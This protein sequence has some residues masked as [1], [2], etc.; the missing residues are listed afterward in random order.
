MLIVTTM[1]GYVEVE[2]P[3]QDLGGGCRH[4]RLLGVRRR[5]GLD[6]ISPRRN[7]AG[8]VAAL[9]ELQRHRQTI[10]HGLAVA[11]Y[12]D[13]AQHPLGRMRMCHMV[14]DSLD[15]LHAMAASVGCRREW[16]QPR[17]FPHYDLPLFRRARAVALGA[18][19]VDRRELARIMRRVRGSPNAAR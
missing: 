8:P 5:R 16:F 19:E 3:V 9:R 10:R 2:Q 4:Y 6:K 18:V 17:S 11:V 12:V 13:D 1:R 7:L 14:A 15:E